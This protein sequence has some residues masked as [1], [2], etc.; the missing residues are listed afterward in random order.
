MS[1]P[2]ILHVSNLGYRAAHRWLLRD[3]TFDAGSGITALLGPN[4]AGKSTLM[5][6]LAGLLTPQRGGFQVGSRESRSNRQR[7]GY[8]PQFPGAYD[9]LTVQEF[10][11]RTAWWDSP[12]E[13]AAIV[14][15]CDEVLERLQ[16]TA[17]RNVLGRCLTPSLRRRVALASLWLRRAEVVLLDEPTAGLD[18]EER[19]AFWRELYRLR[20]LPESPETYLV[21]THL[22]SEVEYYCDALV[23][24]DHGRTRFVGTVQH[25]VETARGHAYCA[26]DLVR[27]AGWVDTGRLSEAGYWVVADQGDPRLS[28]REPDLTDAYLWSIR[29]P[30]LRGEPG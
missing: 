25:F 14:K 26:Q 13:L 6:T 11:V 22:L 15:T 28:P 20:R 24:L 23:L 21:T 8:I 29:G 30:A 1:N 10:L 18:P 9:H 2:E 27:D 4:G 5:R 7:I 16:L 12:R 19:A 3:V 17:V